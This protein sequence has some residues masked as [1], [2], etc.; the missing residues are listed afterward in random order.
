MSATARAGTPDA[1]TGSEVAL[2]PPPG[3]GPSTSAVQ[4]DAP[5]WQAAAQ[6]P[7]VQR[8]RDIAKQVSCLEESSLFE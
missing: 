3:A 5:A 2:G 7:V 1:A 8:S 6:P 4:A